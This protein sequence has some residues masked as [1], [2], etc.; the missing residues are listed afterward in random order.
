[1]KDVGTTAASIA[2]S[3]AASRKRKK[4]GPKRAQKRNNEG[5]VIV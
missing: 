2:C 3:M 4:P 5:K 1:M